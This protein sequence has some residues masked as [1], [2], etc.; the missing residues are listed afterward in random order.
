MPSAI[1]PSAI[2]IF[3]SFQGSKDATLETQ[4]YP[5]LSLI[6]ISHVCSRRKINEIIVKLKEIKILNLISFLINFSMYLKLY[7]NRQFLSNKNFPTSSPKK[8]VFLHFVLF[9]NFG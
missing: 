5:N 6:T 4:I 1:R 9:L 8:E 7:K 2:E 3:N